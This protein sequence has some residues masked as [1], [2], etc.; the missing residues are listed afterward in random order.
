M[1]VGSIMPE[2]AYWEVRLQNQD[3]SPN[4]TLAEA[5][6][7]AIEAGRGD[8]KCGLSAG[9]FVPRAHGGWTSVGT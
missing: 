4:Y 9:V 7:A 5:L 8:H 2:G 1:A 6:E 3:S